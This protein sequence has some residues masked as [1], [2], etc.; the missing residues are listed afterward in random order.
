MVH[1]TS[2]DQDFSLSPIWAW[3]W[4]SYV[5]I[6]NLCIDLSETNKVT[7]K[8][9]STICTLLSRYV[10]YCIAFALV[11]FKKKPW[12][13]WKPKRPENK[14]PFFPPII[15]SNGPLSTKTI[16]NGHFS[17]GMHIADKGKKW[18][19]NLCFF[20]VLYCLWLKLWKSNLNVIFQSSLFTVRNYIS[21]P[22]SQLT[23]L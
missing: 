12:E 22:Y 4:T 21:S 8:N 7:L 6:W 3:S 9:T 2:Q 5:L 18:F 11:I 14:Q 10:Y 1:N 23:L 13:Q 19:K 15:E 16:R 20:L 17:E